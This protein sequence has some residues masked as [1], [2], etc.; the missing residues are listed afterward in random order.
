VSARPAYEAAAALEVLDVRVPGGR[1]R[2]ERDLD[3]LAAHAAAR[4]GRS[5]DLSFVLVGDERMAEMHVRYSGVEG[6]TDVLTF[7]LLEQPVLMGEI[8]VSAET[9]R[10]EAARRAHSAYDE[11]VLYAVHGVMH[12]LG[13]EDDTPASRRRMR[14]AERRAL[15]DLGLAPVFRRTRRHDRRRS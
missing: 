7:P 3:R 10:R 11:V 5:V 15:A 6:P 8:L 1:R 9:A 2:L 4:A 12:L 14:R 13:Y